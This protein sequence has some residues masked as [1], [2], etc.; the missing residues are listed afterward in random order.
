MTRIDAARTFTILGLLAAA[1]CAPSG[2]GSP[3]SGTAS[4]VEIDPGAVTGEFVTYVADYNDGHSEWW[5]AIRTTDGREIRLDFDTPPTAATG[6]QVR[7]HGAAVGERF[8]VSSLEVL[9]KLAV[10]AESAQGA[11]DPELIAAPRQTPTRSCWSISA[12]A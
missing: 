6:N 8:H 9:P 4:P 10:A 3:G 12:A 11:D 5:H 1:G 7:V 2:T